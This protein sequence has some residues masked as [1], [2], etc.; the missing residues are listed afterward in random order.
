[1]NSELV[2]SGF[3]WYIIFLFSLVCHEAAHAWAGLKLGDNT[4]YLHGQVSLNPIP[5]IKREILGT[6]IVPIF[7]FFTS[8]W[9][10]G[11]ASTPYNLQWAM[12]HPKK[13]AKMAL[14]GP[15]ANLALMLAATL[16]IRIGIFINIFQP[17]DFINFS[18]IVQSSAGPTGE[19]LATLVSILFSLNL[20]L[21][22]FNLFPLPGFD[23][24]SIIYLFVKNETA[25][26]LRSFFSHPGLLFLSIFIAWKIFSVIFPYIHFISI[27]MLYPGIHYQ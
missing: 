6:V 22:F 15:A 23:G 10:F 20:I 8:G 3:I 9:M 5:H 1:M 7:V 13:S 16:A 25:A 26:K 11:W 18:H 19:F 21:L 4:A 24:G 17:P 14:A 12:D 2:L 27:Q